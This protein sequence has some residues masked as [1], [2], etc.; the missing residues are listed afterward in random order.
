MV[1]KSNG[2]EEFREKSAHLSL[3][4]QQVGMLY[5]FFQDMIPPQGL[6]HK[7]KELGGR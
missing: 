2:A 4:M 3:R 7:C 6:A 5:D 1:S